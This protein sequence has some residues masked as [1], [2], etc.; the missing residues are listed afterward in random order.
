MTGEY[1]PEDERREIAWLEQKARELVERQRTVHERVTCPTC[2]APVGEPCHR[3]RKDG[4][5]NGEVLRHPHP[6]RL[7]ADGIPWR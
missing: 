1:E 3:R 4:W 6:G 5:R 2:E 7:R